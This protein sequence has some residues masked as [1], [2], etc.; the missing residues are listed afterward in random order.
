MDPRLAPPSQEGVDHGWRQGQEEEGCVVSP[1]RCF[2]GQGASPNAGSRLTFSLVAN[3]LIRS[4]SPTL[5]SLPT[6]QMK[7]KPVQGMS[8][9]A[10]KL[11]RSEKP[12][13]RQAAREAAVAE[14]KARAAKKATKGTVKK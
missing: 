10:I 14:V 9:E 3:S 4:L 11:K 5:S 6:V 1:L 8:V 7:F 12:A 2:A 13:V